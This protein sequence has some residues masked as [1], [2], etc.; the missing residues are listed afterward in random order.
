MTKAKKILFWKEVEEIRNRHALFF[1]E[2]QKFYI[3]IQENNSGQELVFLDGYHLSNGIS[4]EIQFAFKLL[5]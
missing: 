1:P 4:L 3:S 5:N 2:A